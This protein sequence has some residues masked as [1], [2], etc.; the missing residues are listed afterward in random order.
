M[1]ARSHS[2]NQK[3]ESQI[4]PTTP[5]PGINVVGKRNFGLAIN[6]ETY[7]TML[8][9]IDES[10]SDYESRIDK[11]RRFLDSLEKRHFEANLEI[12]QR[13]FIHDVSALKSVEYDLNKI[14][15]VSSPGVQGGEGG[16][17]V[18]ATAACRAEGLRIRFRTPRFSGRSESDS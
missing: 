11:I 10:K 9:E 4:F 12:L 15:T 13:L 16:R 8:R 2:A 18:V 6:E 5:T 7:R 14:I 1:K 3:P 17:P